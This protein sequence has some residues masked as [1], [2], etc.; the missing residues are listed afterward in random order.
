MDADEF[1]EVAPELTRLSSN[2]GFDARDLRAAF[3]VTS[4]PTAAIPH[5]GSL[6]QL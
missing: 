4:W 5:G 1:K 6:L 2:P 3:K